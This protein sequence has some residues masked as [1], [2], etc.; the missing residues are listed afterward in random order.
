MKKGVV[1]ACAAL[2]LSACGGTT[3][4]SGDQLGFV[5]ADGSAVVKNISE[6]SEVVDISGMTIGSDSAWTLS[7]SRGKVVLL[8]SWGPWCAPCRK[9][10]PTLQE[11]SDEFAASGLVVVGLATRTTAV[12]TLAFTRKHN[13]TFEQVADFNSALMSQLP[14]IPS[15]TVPG[16]IFIDRKG[17]IAGWALGEAD[18]AL[19]RSITQSLLEEK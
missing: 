15:A 14:G 8:N 18:P 7:D 4:S 19:I 17:R 6:R 9:E 2:L 16:T 11:L 13:I 3:I 10:L 12:E 1:L 5:S